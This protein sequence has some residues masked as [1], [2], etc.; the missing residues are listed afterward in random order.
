MLDDRKD[1]D[2]GMTKKKKSNRNFNEKQSQSNKRLKPSGELAKDEQTTKKQQTIPTSRKETCW[3]KIIMT[4]KGNEN[5]TNDEFD[6]T[7][8]INRNLTGD[9]SELM[10][11]IRKILNKRCYKMNALPFQFENSEAA[12]KTNAEILDSNN[13]NLRK[14]IERCQRTVFHPGTEFREINDLRHLLGKHKDWPKFEKILRVGVEYGFKKDL[15]YTEKQRL[16]DLKVSLERGNNKSALDP[17]HFDFIHENYLK[18]V[19]KGW[20]IPIP[21]MDI[22]KIKGCGVIPIGIVKQFTINENGE[23]IEKHRLTHDCLNVRDSG[24]SVNNMVD[25]ELL[26]NCIYGFCLLQ[27]LHN[28]QSM[29]IRHPTDK[30][31]INKTDLDAAFPRLHVLLEHAVMCITVVGTMGYILGRCPFGTN[32]GP[33]KFCVTSEI[34]ID[35]SQE[36]ADDPTWNP[37]DLKSPHYERFPAVEEN[38]NNTE[39]FA[40]AMPLLHQIAEKQIYIDGFIDDIMTIAVGNEKERLQ[41]AQ[42]AVPLVLH[43]IFRPIQHDEPTVQ[44]DILSLRKLLGEGAL[45]EIKIVLGWLIDTRRF[46]IKLPE[47]KA[48]AWT[49]ELDDYIQRSMNNHTISED[50]LESLIGKLNHA[51]HILREGRYFLSRLCYRLKLAKKSRR[52]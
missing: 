31:Y 48:R 8:R 37:S 46:V 15:V 32:E 23:R 35:L 29:R 9:E 12:V 41:R 36:I 24:N 38:F 4:R 25:E 7:Q 47:D 14:V 40:K 28:I 21:K 3:T 5:R 2:E 11:V 17:A 42:G 50:E 20:M 18:E 30:I 33:G 27:I 6:K 49:I 45:S 1:I 51:S 43:A 52:K 16:Q 22:S 44:D 39:T 34:V 26:E 13:G 10:R 19:C